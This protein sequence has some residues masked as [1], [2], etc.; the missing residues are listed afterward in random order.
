M[1]KVVKMIFVVIVF[2]SDY[3]LVFSQAVMWQRVYDY[4]GKQTAGRDVIQTFDGGY[5]VCGTIVNP[6]RIY[7][8]KL[9]YLGI[10]EWENIIR[11]SSGDIPAVKQKDGH[12]F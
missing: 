1:K 10:V 4:N 8:I 5:I 7:L 11:D 3:S 6:V 12:F 2:L 9:N